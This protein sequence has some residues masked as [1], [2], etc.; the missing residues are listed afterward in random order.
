MKTRSHARYYHER[1]IAAVKAVDPEMLVAEGVFVP[2]A[3]GMDGIQHA[4]V[5][6]GKKGD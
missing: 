2:R 6:P 5:W 3:V 1:I 4:G